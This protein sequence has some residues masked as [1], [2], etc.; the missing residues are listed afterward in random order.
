MET[1]AESH[2]QNSD[3]TS[4]A[5]IRNA[6]LHQFA[7]SGFAGTPMRAIAAEAGV[8]IGL[9][10]HHFGSKEG[11]KEAVESWIVE[12]FANAIA[13][14]DAQ[15][16]GSVASAASR[17]TSVAEMMQENPLIVAYLRRDLLEEGGTHA[18]ITRLSHLSGE[19][20]DSLRDHGKASQDRN[21][22]EQVVNV[23]VRQLGKLFLQPLID[24]IV[25]SFPEKEQ[26]EQTPELHVTVTTQD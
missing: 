25:L 17:D 23:M 26:P 18:L 19:S 15:A 6:G 2:G 9:I 1:E 14:A 10:S 4:R 8:T 20:I 21:R 13:R 22:V 11:L 5:R 16:G 7:T 12:Q 24:Q 3:L